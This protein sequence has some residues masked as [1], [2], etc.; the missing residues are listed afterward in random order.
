MEHSVEHSSNNNLSSVTKNFH[1]KSLRRDAVAE[2]YTPETNVFME[3]RQ[4][5][6]HKPQIK[7]KNYISEANVLNYFSN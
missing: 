6:S 3:K 4:Q 1:S 7:T 5:A 2:T